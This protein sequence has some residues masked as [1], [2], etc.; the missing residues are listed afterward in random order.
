M[1]IYLVRHPQ[2]MAVPGICYGGSD[3]ACSQEELES[4]AAKLLPALPKALKI[5][6][7]PLS[8]CEQLVQVLCRLEA[9]F[10]YETDEK[11]A[12]MH[13]GAWEMMP[14]DQISPLELAAWTDDFASYRCGGTGESTAMLLRRVAKRLHASAVQGED[15]IWITHA[16][17]IRAMQWLGAQPY[18]VFASLIKSIDPAQHLSLLAADWPRGE[19]AFGQVC[20][21]RPWDWPAEWP[22]KG[23]AV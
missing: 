10:V 18:A 22:T 5:I 4:A 13:F 9:S 8:R 7:S 3:V 12:E 14:W 1:Q 20:Q 17:V 23:S 16:G 6:S 21:S 2:T 11:L 15:Q 19:V